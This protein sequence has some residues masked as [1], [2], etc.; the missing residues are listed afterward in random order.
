MSTDIS[1]NNE[2]FSVTQNQKCKYTLPHFVKYD[3]Y[4]GYYICF[5]RCCN[6]EKSD[7]NKFSS[8]KKLYE[9]YSNTNMKSLVTTCRRCKKYNN[10]TIIFLNIESMRK[11][12]FDVY[13]KQY[14]DEK[15]DISNNKYITSTQDTGPTNMFSLLDN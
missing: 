4:N 7:N 13:H 3:E 2:G 5:C 1:M 12:H 10:S 8:L 11:D 9:H 15:K 6:L 14:Y